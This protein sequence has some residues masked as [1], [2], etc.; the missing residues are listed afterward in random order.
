M[1]VVAYIADS[2]SGTLDDVLIDDLKDVHEQN[3]SDEK[4]E[5]LGIF[6]Y[7]KTGLPELPD[8]VMILIGRG[9][10][11]ENDWE[12]TDTVTYITWEKE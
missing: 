5:E 12:S 8:D 4:L 6:K 2:N 11:F 7:E 10:F 3:L 9:L 1:R